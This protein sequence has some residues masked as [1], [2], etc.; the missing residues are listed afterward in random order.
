MPASRRN[1]GTLAPVKQT[2]A[3]AVV[4]PSQPDY[5]ADFDKATSTFTLVPKRVLDGSEPTDVLPAA[6]ISGAPME[7]QARTVR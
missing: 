2:P 4:K 5:A 3:P 1:E 7:L 6:I